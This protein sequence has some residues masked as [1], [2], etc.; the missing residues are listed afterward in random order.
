MVLIYCIMEKYS[1]SYDLFF[2]E[3]TDV[4]PC[5]NMPFI[6]SSGYLKRKVLVFLTIYLFSFIYFGCTRSSLWHAGSS[7]Q[8]ADFLVAACVQDLVPWPRIKPGSPA[9]GAQR[10]T[11]WTTREAPSPSLFTRLWWLI[12]CV[13]LTRPWVPRHLVK[14]AGF[15]TRTG[16]TLLALLGLRLAKC[17][18]WD[19]S[20]PLWAPFS[21]SIITWAN[22][23]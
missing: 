19:F 12:L 8:L 11:H 13:N 10:L 16:T 15:Q 4:A 7:L 18:S 6:L 22:S 5:L 14:H 2:Q 21:A 20:A 17:R 23:L 3:I 1:S 9:L